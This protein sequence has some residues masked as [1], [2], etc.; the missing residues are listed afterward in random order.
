M[1]LASIE[2]LAD[3][4]GEVNQI[5]IRALFDLDNDSSTAEIDTLTVDQISKAETAQTLTGLDRPDLMLGSDESDTISGGAGNDVI[6]GFDGADILTGGTGQDDIRAGG[7][8]DIVRNS[9][10]TEVG[11]KIDGGEGRDTLEI[12]AVGEINALIGVLD[13]QSIEVIDADN[14]QNTLSLTFDEIVDLSESPDQSLEA[15]LA[16]ALPNAHSVYGNDGDTLTLDGQGIYS[17]NQTD[18]V[19]DASGADLAVY[20]FSIGAGSALATVGVSTNN[21]VA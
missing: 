8:D 12:E 16:A 15:L 14:G 13:I 6:L 4:L 9:A 5:S 19:T 7:G 10:L 3:L 20:T 1:P 11:D 18:T 2:N 17:V 21:V